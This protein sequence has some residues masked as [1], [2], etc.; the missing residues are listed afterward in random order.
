MSMRYISENEFRAYFRPPHPRVLKRT[1]IDPHTAFPIRPDSPGRVQGTQDVDPGD[2][3]R[4]PRG[5]SV[6]PRGAPVDYIAVRGQAPRRG[7]HA[8]SLGQCRRGIWPDRRGV[9]R[10]RGGEP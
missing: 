1:P 5:V 7:R 2:T 9:D 6:E 3:I 4:E 8:H 10:W